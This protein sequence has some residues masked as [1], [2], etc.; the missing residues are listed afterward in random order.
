MLPLVLP[1]PE[2]DPVM[3][4]LGPVAIRWYSMA[5]IAGI[6]CAFFYVRRLL[7]VERLWGWAPEKKPP[8][9]PDVLEDYV[10]WAALGVIV[11]GRIGYLL[12]YG[13]P[14]NAEVY[15][16][17]PLRIIKV[18][19]GGM[20]FHGGFLGVILAT[21]LYARRKGMDMFLLADMVAGGA[22][23]G[24]FFGRLANFING[25][26]WGRV[27]DV[28]WAMVFPTGGP[29]PRHPSQLYE[30]ALEGLFLFLAIAFMTYRMG[31]LAK[32]GFL[33]GVFFVWYGAARIFV[34][35]FRDS[36]TRPFGPDH[37]LTQGMLLSSFMIFVGGWFIWRSLQPDGGAS[38]PVFAPL[39]WNEETAAKAGK[40][41][42]AQPAKGKAAAKDGKKATSSKT[43]SK[44]KT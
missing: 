4:A 10:F 36:P 25:E 33:A 12:F 43:R 13:L 11:G 29:F 2:I 23:I 38:R 16:A 3:I 1:Y 42:Y 21:I 14:Y 30:A 39:P 40:S 28:P 5:Y 20:S 44:P 6:A 31:L 24:L 17:D 18:W 41:A 9:G 7:F 19:E 35:F 32:R 22:P 26:L 37:W 34:E 27:S 8:F 15:L